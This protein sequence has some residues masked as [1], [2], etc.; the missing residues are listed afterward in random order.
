MSSIPKPE[1]P[2]KTGAPCVKVPGSSRVPV[3]DEQT[4]PHRPR[5]VVSR[6]TCPPLSPLP[7]LYRYCSNKH[8]HTPSFRFKRAAFYQS[9][10]S[11]VGSLRRR[12]KLL[13]PPLILV[14]LACASSNSSRARP[15]VAEHACRLAETHLLRLLLPPSQK[16]TDRSE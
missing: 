5:L 13:A 12:L 3:H 7:A 14:E 2:G 6:S 11:K 10:K 15:L 16:L 8:T 9:L 1:E 4:S